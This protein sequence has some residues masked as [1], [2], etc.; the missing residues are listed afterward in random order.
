MAKLLVQLVTRPGITPN[1]NTVAGD[2]VEILPEGNQWMPSPEA[3]PFFAVWIV[4]GKPSADYEWL[5]DKVYG[6][7]NSEN[8]TPV[9]LQRKFTINLDDMELKGIIGSSL[10][11]DFDTSE[12]ADVLSRAIVARA[13]PAQIPDFVTLG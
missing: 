11:V 12:K 10:V 4:H 6:E 13:V 3:E 7:P 1:V 9:L 2:V 5:T 8:V